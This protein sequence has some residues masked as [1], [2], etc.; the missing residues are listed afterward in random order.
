MLPPTAV[1]A[2]AESSWTPFSKMLA[3]LVITSTPGSGLLIAALKVKGGA[4][5][6]FGDCAVG[7][8]REALPAVPL[9]HR[10]PGVVA[11]VV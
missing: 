7:Q 10:F 4:T 9:N 3:T 8:V 11:E 1:C 5:M 2:V 6:A